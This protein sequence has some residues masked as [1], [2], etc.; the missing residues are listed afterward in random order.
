RAGQY[1]AV[2]VINHLFVECI[3]NALGDTT[4]DLPFDDHRVNELSGVLD[5]YEPLDLDLARRNVDPDDRNMA[6]VGAG[7]VRVVG[8][9]GRDPGCGNR[10][11]G[12]ALVIGGAR[13]CRT[14]VQRSVPRTKAR[15]PAISMSD[16]AA[17]KIWPATACRRSRSFVAASLQAPPAI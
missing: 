2:S 8:R 5:G 15:P 12:V 13:Q 14:S 4:M 1:V 6:G 3:G 9:D 17:S 10:F 16:A 11:E 7:A